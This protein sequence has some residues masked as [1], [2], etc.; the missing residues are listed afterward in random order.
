MPLAVRIVLTVRG[1][2]F[3]TQPGRHRAT[4]RSA[5]D[6]SSRQGCEVQRTARLLRVEPP[7]QGH[8]DRGHIEPNPLPVR[9]R[10]RTGP[11]DPEVTS[12][13]PSEGS[14]IMTTLHASLDQV[15]RT[16]F[17]PVAG[18]IPGLGERGS[19]QIL[20][21]PKLKLGCGRQTS[22][23][24]SSAGGPANWEHRTKSGKHGAASLRHRGHP[25]GKPRAGGHD[26]IRRKRA[27]R[28]PFVGGSCPARS[29]D[30][31]LS[32]PVRSQNRNFRHAAINAVQSP[33]L[34]RGMNPSSRLSATPAFSKS[35]VAAAA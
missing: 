19:N 17:D 10:F 13:E 18:R 4:P 12:R 1:I 31:Y 30:D 7:R 6:G 5:E 33:G 14:R 9:P 23:L 35:G 27:G 25:W 22:G 8:V 11:D 26:L 2:L 34:F 29:G 3:L 21:Q 20:E 28:L 16:H 24:I 15:G 32:A